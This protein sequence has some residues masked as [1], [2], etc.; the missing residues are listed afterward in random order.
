M[1][2]VSLTSQEETH[3]YQG[4]PVRT[5]AALTASYVY[6]SWID[7]RLHDFVDWVIYLTAQG[8][9]TR[10]DFSIQFSVEI[11]PNDT[12]DW[13]TLQAEDID[14]SGISTLSDYEIR[15]TI[16]STVTLGMTAPA[17]GRWMR[18]GIKAGAGSA[19][20]SECSI[21]VLRRRPRKN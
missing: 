17:R 6:T 15:K 19:T 12:T 20:G 11:S 9:I 3:N 10:L 13:A 1:P 8:S 14:S 7:V 4:A 21:D 18:L 2:V 16:S 5:A